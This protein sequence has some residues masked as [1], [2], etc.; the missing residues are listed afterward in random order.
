MSGL[1]QDSGSTPDSRRAEADKL[2]AIIED[3][4]E[5][6]TPKEASFVEQVWSADFISPKQLF[7]LRDIKDKYL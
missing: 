1:F 5:Q 6:L 2:L 3:F 4:S 7:W